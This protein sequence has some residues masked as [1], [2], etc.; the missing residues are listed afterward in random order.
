MN[1]DQKESNRI[2]SNGKKVTI[3]ARK[4]NGETQQSH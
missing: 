2:K 1:G 4:S 3:L